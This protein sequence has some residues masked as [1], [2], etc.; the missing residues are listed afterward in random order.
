MKIAALLSLVL[1]AATG[2][3]AAPS[4][5]GSVIR[6]GDKYRMWYSAKSDRANST[7]NLTPSARI[8]YAESDDGL[9]WTK[10]DLGLA[11][12]NGNKHNNLV[13]LAP[14]LDQARN[15]PLACFVLHE[16]DDPDPARRYKMAVYAVYYPTDAERKA[17]GMPADNNP[18]TILP[19]VSAD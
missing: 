10:P 12:F 1:C 11:D 7:G 13:S 6:V 8:A 15:E 16:P 4:F 9:H 2:L 18:S 19:Y 3:R 5:Y 17:T 14:V